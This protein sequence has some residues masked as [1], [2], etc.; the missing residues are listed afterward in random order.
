VRAENVAAEKI[1]GLRGVFA[2]GKRETFREEVLALSFYASAAL[3][4]ARMQK[5]VTPWLNETMDEIAKAALNDAKTQ[6]GSG[7]DAKP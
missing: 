1:P 7:A 2:G 3:M 4:Q 5:M 6:A